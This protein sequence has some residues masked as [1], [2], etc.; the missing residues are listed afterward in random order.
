MEGGLFRGLYCSGILGGSPLKELQPNEYAMLSSRVPP[1]QQQQA[2]TGNA[3]MNFVKKFVGDKANEGEQ[4]RFEQ[5]ES[6]I[7]PDLLQPFKCGCENSLEPCSKILDITKSNLEHMKSEYIAGKRSR[8]QYGYLPINQHLLQLVPATFPET[9][10]A[11]LENIFRQTS[12][13]E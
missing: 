13:S 2:P 11:Q 9:L 6:P 4:L 1:V 10:T 7:L 12:V 8:E 5:L 3:W